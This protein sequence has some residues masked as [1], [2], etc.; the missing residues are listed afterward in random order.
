ML[1]V[2]QQPRNNGAQDSKARGV[3]TSDS[4]LPSPGEE[5][6]AVIQ[7]RELEATEDLGDVAPEGTAEA[8]ELETETEEEGEEHESEEIEERED[9]SLGSKKKGP[10]KRKR[11]PAAKRAVRKAKGRR[12]VHKHS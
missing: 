11:K 3:L 10:S 8:D 9:A 5:A 2:I 7:E 1:L 4:D 12:T 6:E